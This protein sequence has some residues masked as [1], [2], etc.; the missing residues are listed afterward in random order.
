M[1]LF[2]YFRK[3][4]PVTLNLPVKHM[5]R[6]RNT[7]VLELRS[8]LIQATNNRLNASW[9]GLD[10]QSPDD[11]FATNIINLRKLSRRMTKEDAITKSWYEALVT[12]VIGSHGIKFVPKI[13]RGNTSAAAL[14][15]SVNKEL[16]RAW[17]KF[18]KVCTV[19]RKAD[20]IGLQEQAIFTVS[21]DGECFVNVIIDRD[22]N[23]FGIALEILDVT[24]L[25]P[26]YTVNLK[27]GNGIR[28]IRQGIEL[29]KYDRAVAYWFWN[30]YPNSKS[31]PG[32]LK[33]VRVP[34]LDLD[35]P[36][37]QSGVIHLHYEAKDAANSLRGMPW[38]ISV[39][40]WLARLNQYLDAEL[41][42]AVMSSMMPGVI[43]TDKN[44]A[45]QYTD[46]TF[47]NVD[48]DSSL[49]SDGS[50]ELPKGP[51]HERIEYESGVMLKLAPGEKVE[52]PGF[53]RPNQAMQ[54][55]TNL[56]L[57][58]I[59][60]GLGIAYSTLTSDTSQESYASGRLGVMQE[61]DQWKRIQA[62][63]ARA[64]HQ[65]VYE[66]WIRSALRTPAL[67]LPGTS[68]DYQEIEFRPRGW[69]W[70]DQ[71]R[72]VKA[73]VE[74]M[75]MGVFPPSQ[76]A[77]E[78]GSD[79]EETVAQTAADFEMMTKAGLDPSV[80]FAANVSAV[81]PSPDGKTAKELEED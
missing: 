59:A 30:K 70:A 60:A 67:D 49:D 42:A 10:L 52:V 32:E 5:P 24:L 12:N 36:G 81:N 14:N 27:S 71:L 55:A 22:V 76:I 50:L 79:Y 39:L 31:N 40:D 2:K 48:R 13:R 4:E 34:A 61:R 9:Y 15:A 8:Q 46:P 62:W 56:Y 51:E 57:H 38:L 35:K 80:I 44:D 19:T 3:K 37:L 75:K 53:D 73:V 69:K 29:D 63:F 33:R 1:D 72:E 45:S 16:R 18:E 65:K 11:L 43:T 64:L 28:K 74:Q 54:T 58:A 23:E 41:I 25:D 78:F 26:E 21:E 47:T 68:E 66:A 17:K 7:P 6:P 77:E 20:W